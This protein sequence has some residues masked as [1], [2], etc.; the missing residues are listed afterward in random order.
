MEIKQYGFVAPVIT[1]EDYTFGS[2]QLGAEILQPDGQWDDYLPPEEL[3][4][5]RGVES[6]SC[7]SFATLTSIQILLKRKYGEDK[8]YSE[9]FTA[10]LAETNRIGT[11]PKKVSEAIR[12]KGTIPDTLLPFSSDIASWSEYHS[13][14]PMLM[15]FLDKGLKWLETH[16]FGY[17]W[18]FTGGSL[19]NKKNKLKQALQSSPVCVSVYAWQQN[20][21]YY[22][23][24][25]GV[26]DTHLTV[27]YGYVDGAYWKIF[28]TYDMTHKKLVWEYSFGLAQRYTIDK[29]EINV[30]SESKV[31]WWQDFWLFVIMRRLWA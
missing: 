5:L 11:T 7:V 2:G 25:E 1:E 17:D 3:Q 12:K 9:R 6:M 10:I 31:S 22:I 23:K 18:V 28:D 8:N 26:R 24:P 16:D 19:E 29:K 30:V 4:R 14:T 15:D 20:G 21:E 27:C 13:P